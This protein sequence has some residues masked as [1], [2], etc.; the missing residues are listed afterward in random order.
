MH[1]GEGATKNKMSFSIQNA[2]AETDE[3]N[4]EVLLDKTIVAKLHREPDKLTFEWTPEAAKQASSPCLGNCLLQLNAGT[5]EHFLALRTPVEVDPVTMDFEKGSKW[6]AMVDNPP[7]GTVVELVGLDQGAFPNADFKTETTGKIKGLVMWY[8]GGL[9]T[10]NLGL[11]IDK[12]D[13]SKRIDVTLAPVYRFDAMARDTAAA[14]RLTKKF[15]PQQAAL[16]DQGLKTLTVQSAAIDK[17]G[18]TAEEKER[19]K[20]LVNVELKNMQ[21][22][23]ARITSAA[24]LVQKAHDTAVMHIRVSY[25]TG[26]GKVVLAQTKGAPPPESQAKPAVAE[27]K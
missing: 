23:L 5:D 14:Q 9:D 1:G 24:E 22:Q 18:G 16:L 19:N 21:E 6:T 4:W 20:N 13:G 7:S 27:N 26:A 15:L 8:G 12:K 17:G 11:L 2:N 10:R 25:D 3:R